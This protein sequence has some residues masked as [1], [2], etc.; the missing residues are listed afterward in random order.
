MIRMNTNITINFNGDAQEALKMYAELF[1]L[2]NPEITTY[3]SL[4]PNPDFAI[5]KEEANYVFH[6]KINIG[7]LDIMVQDL[8]KSMQEA[9]NSNITIGVTARSESEL[10]K[11]FEAMENG[12][13]V[14][15]PLQKM[16]WSDLYGA[17]K[18]KFGTSWQFQLI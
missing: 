8:L 10:K 1:G 12:G 13:Q 15:C 14:T 9:Y 18:D 3:G 7:G 17:V 16:P 6:A 5:S 4:P 11:W 2:E